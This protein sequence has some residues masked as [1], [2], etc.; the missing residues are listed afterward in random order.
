[1]KSLISPER[2]SQ[3]KR[4]LY[5]THM[6]MGDYVY[7][8]MFLKKLKAVY[9]HL[10]IDLWFDNCS[11]KEGAWH[12]RRSQTLTEWFK[13]E[14]FLNHLYPVAA[15][16]KERKEMIVRAQQEHY[17]IIV[18]SVDLWCED[19]A[20]VAREISST[21]Y[22]V[23][24]LIKPHKKFFA[25]FNAFRRCNKFFLASSS[26][27]NKRLHITEFYQQ[28]FERLLGLKITKEEIHPHL[29][30]PEYWLKYMQAWLVK[31]KQAHHANEK[32][33]FINYL[34]TNKKR[35]WTFE[36]TRDLIIALNELHPHS[37]YILNLSPP[38]LLSIKDQLSQDKALKNIHVLP[39]SAQTHFYELPALIQLSD[40]VFSVETAVIHLASALSMPQIALVRRKG[41]A[42]APLSNEKTHIIFTK[43][44]FHSRISQITVDDVLMCYKK[45]F[46]NSCCLKK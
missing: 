7:Q 2:L 12:L 20:R 15:S 35:D 44:A 30:V 28:R 37:T 41:K 10:A 22:V 17:D 33:V 5:M 19:Y 39:F 23:G 11:T 13:E 31:E 38:M 4:L 36:Q 8:R 43:P 18:F 27:N 6:A 14:P 3:A 32:T 42:W 40:W 34:S 1:M 25:K 21:A 26:M 16:L 9:P 29:E 46:K 24:T 45:I